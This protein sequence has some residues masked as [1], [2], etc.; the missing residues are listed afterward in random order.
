[1]IEAILL[2]A[3]RVFIRAS[4]LDDTELFLLDPIKE[5]RRP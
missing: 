3:S 2:T 4:G 5:P 1:M